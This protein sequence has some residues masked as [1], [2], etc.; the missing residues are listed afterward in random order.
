VPLPELPSG[1]EYLTESG[2]FIFDG[3]VLSGVALVLAANEVGDLLILGLLNSRFVVLRSLAKSVLLNR[4]DAC[5]S[6]FD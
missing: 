1:T 3:K 5:Y 6:N 4:I 2:L